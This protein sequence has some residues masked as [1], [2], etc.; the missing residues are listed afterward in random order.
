MNKALHFLLTAPLRRP[1]V[2]FLAVANMLGALY[3]FQWY[4]G[5]LAQTPYLL[6]P[7]IPD[8]PLSALLFSLVL[9]GLL[10]RRRSGVLEGI[11]F[12]GIAKY[13]LWSVAVIG[14][15]WIT[16]AFGGF[17]LIHLF[18]SHWI[19]A[20]QGIWF[21]YHYYPGPGYV[22]V[23]AAW[24]VANDAVDYLLGHHPSLPGAGQLP[25]ARAAALALTLLVPSLLLWLG[26]QSPSREDIPG[27]Y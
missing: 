12:V 11:A 13:G 2:I 8:S 27:D 3:G 15:F 23:G 14:H 10:C 17:E 5:Q 16:R 4:R 19:M 22:L 26:T 7:F 25:F 9:V 1:V 18:L 24:A 6:W 20:L 21:A